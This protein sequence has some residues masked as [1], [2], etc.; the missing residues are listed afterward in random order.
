PNLFNIFFGSTYRTGRK[1]AMPAKVFRSAMDNNVDTEISRYLVDR[2]G[3]GIVYH[4]QNTVLLAQF[5]NIFQ[6][7][8]IEVGVGGCLNKNKFR[9]RLYSCLESIVVCLINLCYF[10]TI[11]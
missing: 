6:I 9:I 11:L 3:K 2:G 1:V 7:G 5:A 8:N 10:Y 4:S